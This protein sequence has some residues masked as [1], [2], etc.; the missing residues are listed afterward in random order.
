MELGPGSRLEKKYKDQGV[1]WL[2]LNYWGKTV[3]TTKPQGAK[4]KFTL[5]YIYLL[6]GNIC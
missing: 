2:F 3:K 4:R 6:N 1:K 5:L